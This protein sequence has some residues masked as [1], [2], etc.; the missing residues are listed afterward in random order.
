MVDKNND[1]CEYTDNEEIWVDLNDLVDISQ[2]Q[3]F[4]EASNAFDHY[5]EEYAKKV[6]MTQEAK[7]EICQLAAHATK[8]AMEFCFLRGFEMGA[9][10]AKSCMEEDRELQDLPKST[11]PVS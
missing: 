10:I 4:M 8:K 6:H 7:T 5:M 2:S 3:D 9:R 11:L 1:N